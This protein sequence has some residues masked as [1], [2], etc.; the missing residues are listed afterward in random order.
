LKTRC[1]AEGQ[2]MTA[3]LEGPVRGWVGAPIAEE[4]V[5][6]GPRTSAPVRRR[7][8]A[9]VGKALKAAAV[10]PVVSTGCRRCGHEQR[11][12]EG[13]C[14]RMWVFGPAVPAP[15]DPR[16][17]WDRGRG[18]HRRRGAV[19]SGAGCRRRVGDMPRR[20]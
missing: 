10:A 5:P 14:G 2:A 8:V 15:G 4:P 18:I 12:V 3:V 20:G 19:R 13:V 6:E 11:L 9:D 17:W 1:V 16:T 7:K